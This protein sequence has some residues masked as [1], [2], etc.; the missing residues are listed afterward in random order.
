MDLVSGTE[1]QEN[2]IFFGTDGI[3]GKAETLFTAE[4]LH[5][6]GFFS[7]KVLPKKKPILIG[8]DSRLSSPKIVTGLANGLMGY[9]RPLLCLF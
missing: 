1:P 6:L 4:L 8:Q 3:R 2:I 5:K 7:D 9:V